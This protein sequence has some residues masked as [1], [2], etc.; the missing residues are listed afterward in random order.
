MKNHLY[1]VCPHCQHP[2]IHVEDGKLTKH[3]IATNSP[4]ACIGSEMQATE[5]RAYPIRRG[6]REYAQALAGPEL[7]EQNGFWTWRF[8]GI[9]FLAAP[10]DRGNVHIC[11]AF[12]N[13]YGSWMSV[14]EFRKR[15]QKGV[16]ADWQALGKCRV[17]IVPIR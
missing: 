17:Q 5:S 3:T 9:D 11:D 4:V 14:E 6:T 10:I 1:S 16:I 13:N 15:Q 2:N 7:P 8:S 12:G